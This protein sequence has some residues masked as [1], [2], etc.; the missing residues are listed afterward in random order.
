MRHGSLCSGYLGLDAAVDAVFGGELA[1]VADNAPGASALLAHRLPHVPN[2]GDIKAIDWAAVEP[3]DLLTAGYPCQPFSDAGRRKGTT[4]DRH[5]WPHIA[6]AVRHLRPRVVVLEN[7]RGHLNRGFD[8]VLGTLADLGYDASWTCVRASDVGAPHR[9]E[10]LFVVA[11]DTDDEP[12]RRPWDS[13]RRNGDASSSRGAPDVRRRGSAVA[14]AG[15]GGRQGHA[16]LDGGAHTGVNGTRGAHPD[17]RAVWG[18]YGPAVQQWERITGRPAPEPTEPGRNGQRL[19][20]RFVEWLMGLPDGWVTEVPG[21][22]RNQMLTLLGNGVVTR[23]AEHA[24]RE[25]TS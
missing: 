12:W 20:P 16:Q 13:L 6:D 11:A 24:L 14:D 21:L 9:R 8:T 4:D 19:S 7:V 10:R 5:L 2:L 25:L 23:Q 22:T 15:R 1:W 3:V 17:G 18:Q